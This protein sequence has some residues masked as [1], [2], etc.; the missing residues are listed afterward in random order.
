MDT[1]IIILLAVLLVAAVAAIFIVRKLTADQA[2]QK[3]IEHR[4]QEAEAVL[5]SAEQEAREKVAE[6]ERRI[7]D[8][9]RMLEDAS[10]KAETKKKEALVE[11]K[12]EIH[13]LRSDAEKEIRDRRSEVTKQERRIHQKEETLD[14][15]LDKTGGVVS[16]DLSVEGNTYMRNLRLEEFLEVPEFRYNRVETTVG[17]QWSAPGAGIVE[18]VDRETCRLVIKLEVGEIM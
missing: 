6:A 14:K 7:A 17:D 3:G 18:L 13:K 8:A 2:F 1:I 11:A 16:G 15:K 10:K 12:D 4:K 5:G 9:Q